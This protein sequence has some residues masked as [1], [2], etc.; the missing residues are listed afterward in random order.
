MINKT[1]IYFALKV[2]DT[3]FIRVIHRDVLNYYTTRLTLFSLA[4][5]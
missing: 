5:Q 1:F 2:L 4:A 3:I